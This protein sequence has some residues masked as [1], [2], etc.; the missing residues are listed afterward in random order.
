VKLF[1]FILFPTKHKFMKGLIISS[2]RV[3]LE[4]CQVVSAAAG[5]TNVD[6]ASLEDLFAGQ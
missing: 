3:S 6:A 4:Q 1:L 2:K 5:D